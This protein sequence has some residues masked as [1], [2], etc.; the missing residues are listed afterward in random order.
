MRSHPSENP[1]V[2]I[3]L[4]LAALVCLAATSARAGERPRVLVLAMDS[5]P[6]YIVERY[7][8][9]AGP[10]SVIARLGT[11]AGLVSS[12][13]AVSYSAWTGILEPF[14]V[15]RPLGYYGKYYDRN[16]SQVTGFTSDWLTSDRPI[17]QSPWHYFFHWRL[18]SV[19]DKARAYMWPEDAGFREARDALDVF[20]R[21]DREIFFAYVVSTDAIA[22]TAGPDALLLF[23]QRLDGLLSRRADANGRLPFTLVMLSDH[24]VAGG[25]VVENV[26][27]A[28]EATLSD[29]GFTFGDSIQEDDDVAIIRVGMV[30]AYEVYTADSRRHEVAQRLA[31]V[32]GTRFCVSREDETVHVYGRQGEGTIRR[33]ARG[34]EEARFA[35]TWTGIDPLDLE[36]VLDE[37]QSAAPDAD[38]DF[39]SDSAWFDATW[40]TDTPDALYRLY[41][42]FDAVENPASLLCSLESGYAFGATGLAWVSWLAHGDFRWTH[43]ALTRTGSVGFISS[44][45]PEWRPGP[46]VR[47]NEA[48]RFLTG[49]DRARDAGRN[50]SAGTGEGAGHS[51]PP[52]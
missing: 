37:L 28:V 30:T 31:G 18:S 25:E 35:Y 5:I 46:A 4:G 33:K 15:D 22:H 52:T 14:G 47:F 21:S 50:P 13:P 6:L 48:L 16:T 10:D 19:M 17:A 32:E 40:K 36:P 24:G 38:P 9:E 51:D 29:A 49:S 45:A 43:G 2:G 23:L 7:I 8:E 12:F 39:F 1:S 42:S 11:P 20:E 26:W 34:G 41:R 27:P 44:N 3:L